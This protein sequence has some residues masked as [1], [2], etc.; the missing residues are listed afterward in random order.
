MAK[1][2]LMED[3]P[4][5]RRILVRQ[6]RDAG[7]TVAA[8]EDGEQSRNRGIVGDADVLITD[9][10]MP[11]ID[12]KTVIRNVSRLRPNLPIIVI[13]GTVPDA[14]VDLKSVDMVLHKPFGEEKLID[15]IETVLRAKGRHSLAIDSH[16]ETR[17]RETATRSSGSTRGRRGS[18]LASAIRELL[19]R[20]NKSNNPNDRDGLAGSLECA[21]VFRSRETF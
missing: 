13:T 7:H 2:F 11:G 6:I 9:L 3:S 16:K 8:F 4:P 17:F 10:S 19:G 18:R 5:L 21:P 20:H 14:V 1:I 12:G 15:A